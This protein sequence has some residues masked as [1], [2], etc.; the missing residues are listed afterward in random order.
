MGYYSELSGWVLKCNHRYPNKRKK[1]GRGGFWHTEGGRESMGIR[2]AKMG[3]MRPQAKECWQPP[4]AK[5]GKELVLPRPPG[6][7]LVAQMVKNLVVMHETQV[8]IPGWGRSPAGENGYPLQYSS[9][10][11]PMDRGGLHTVHWVAKS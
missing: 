8:L 1:K 6:A 2:R 3:V 7:S 11:N 5:R 4:E 9:L 10:G